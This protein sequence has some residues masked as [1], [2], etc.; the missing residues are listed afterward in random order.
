L[1]EPARAAQIEAML[2]EREWFETAAF[3]S[4]LQQMKSMRLLPWQSP[5]CWL[6]S[7]V[8]VEPEIMEIGRRLA[9]LGLSQ[10]EPNPIA[11]I[12]QAKRPQ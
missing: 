3:C 7:D 2:E 5:P 12:E 1:A 11:A 9:R 6:S 10:F 8:K 4:Y